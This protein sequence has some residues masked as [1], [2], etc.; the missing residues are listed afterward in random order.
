MDHQVGRA[1]FNDP[2]RM[3]KDLLYESAEKFL[4]KMFGPTKH[5]QFKKM[6]E[7]EEVFEPNLR[8]LVEEDAIQWVF[9]GGVNSF[10]KLTIAT[11]F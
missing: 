4:N 6:S 5:W 11:E 1:F 2:N 10:V 3:H 9:V 8:H 7:E